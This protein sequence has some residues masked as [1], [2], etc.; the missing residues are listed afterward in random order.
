MVLTKLNK[1]TYKEAKDMLESHLKVIDDD[2]VSIG[3]DS[4]S[5][6]VLDEFQYFQ[7]LDKFQYLQVLTCASMIDGN[8]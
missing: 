3:L 1:A 8:P 6:Q 7:V 4:I 5:V 2:Q